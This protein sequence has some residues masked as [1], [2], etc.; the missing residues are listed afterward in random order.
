MKAVDEEMDGVAREQRKRLETI[1][2]ELADVRRRLDRLYNLVE[3]TDMDI[4]DFRPRIR[5]HRERQERLEDSAAE[6]RAI[7][8]ER[9][10]V[11]DDVNTIAAYAQEMRDF[12]VES[13]LT[14]RRA[15]IESF[16]KEIVVTPDDAL[17]R[18]TVPMPDDSLIP[19][20]ATEKVALNGAVLPSVK[21]GGAYFDGRQNHLRDVV[22]GA[23][24]PPKALCSYCSGLGQSDSRKVPPVP[25][26]PPLAIMPPPLTVSLHQASR[27]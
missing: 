23:F 10:S 7:L 22:G 11:L 20:R 24:R 13:E 26:P 18:Y 19:G 27:S 16:V 5:D 25:C 1:D 6:A 8:A 12:L 4:D 9:R 2:S 15:F 17:M 21:S 14:E 3:T